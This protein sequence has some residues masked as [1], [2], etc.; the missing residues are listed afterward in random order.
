MYH[1]LWEDFQRPYTLRKHTYDKV[2]WQRNIISYFFCVLS[3]DPLLT[4][5]I[6][7]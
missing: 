2:K 7:N 6:Y 4:R 5:V 3:F 1:I